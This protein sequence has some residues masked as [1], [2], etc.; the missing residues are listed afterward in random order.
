[1]FREGDI[2]GLVRSRV[3]RPETMVWRKGLDDWVS[4]SEIHPEWFRFESGDKGAAAAMVA[5][6]EGA[7][8]KALARKL[9]ES[10]GWLRALAALAVAG[11]ILTSIFG[12]VLF[13]IA[14]AVL[15]QGVG[16]IQQATLLGQK[17]ALD[18]GL[19][20]IGLAARLGVIGAIVLA[21]VL[22]IFWAVAEISGWKWGWGI[23]GFG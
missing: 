14:G 22:A 1:M 9:S 17:S 19:R 6:V 12:G 5:A 13:I 2:A 20:R 11:G 23:F 15:F 18:E 21:V 10:A 3:L 4:G 7:Q 8:V 16:D